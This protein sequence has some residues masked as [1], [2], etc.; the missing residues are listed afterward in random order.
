MF[1]IIPFDQ[2]MNRV[3]SFSPFRALDEMEHRL[4][5]DDNLMSAFRTDIRD[6][7][8]AYVMEAELP[9]FKKEEINLDLSD[10]CLTISAEHKE[11]TEEKDEKK[12]SFIKRERYYG[13]YSRSF[14]VTGIDA[15]KI[16]AS[17][18]DGVLRLN[19]PKKAENV[20][21]VRRLEIK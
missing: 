4:F 7:G 9:G 10:D 14:D 19:M 16:E 21:A 18:N 5:G 20:P 1:E 2:R 6:T 11:E 13:A 3:A 17:Y 8:E 15:D 12:N